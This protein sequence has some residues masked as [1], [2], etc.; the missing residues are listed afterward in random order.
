MKALQSI[1]YCRPGKTIICK[2]A[3]PLIYL[4]KKQERVDL[5]DGKK[6]QCKWCLR[7]ESALY[8]GSGFKIK[9]DSGNG[10]HRRLLYD[11]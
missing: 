8:G 6:I 10:G 9:S 5:T 1:L 3:E 7:P 11:Q 4:L 2:S